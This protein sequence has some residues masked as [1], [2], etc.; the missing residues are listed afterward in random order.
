VLLDLY[1]KGVR[2]ASEPAD[3]YLHREILAF[4]K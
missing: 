2:Q 4:D 1:G 3:A